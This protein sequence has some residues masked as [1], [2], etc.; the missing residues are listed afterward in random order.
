MQTHVRLVIVGA[1]IVGC[2]IAHHLT[3]LGWRDIV[4]VDKG[5]LYE[6]GGSSSHAPGLIF[7]TNYSKFMTQCAKYSVALYK[8]LVYNDTQ[9]AYQVGGIEVAYTDARLRE[10]HRKQSAALSYG[11]EGHVITPQEVADMVPVLDPRVIKGGYY[12]PT[13]TDVR[14][15]YCAAA[16]AEKAIAT[17]GATGTIVNDDSASLSIDDVTQ[18]EGLAS[19]GA[20]A[21]T[22]FVFT[23]SS[24]NPSA[25]AMT[26]NFQTADGTAT[27]PTDYV[28]SSGTVTIPPGATS[29]TL[30]ISVIPDTMVEPDETF[31][32]N[33]SAA[34]GASLADAQGLGTILGDDQPNPVPVNDPRALLL[35]IALMLSLAGLS[36]ARRR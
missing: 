10:L 7:Q 36:L 8:D 27:A 13:D 5:P 21:L 15:W 32:V 24:S 11:L 33:L 31:G 23:I 3:Q 14:G 29:A 35:L 12:V 26:V 18:F 2:S 1:G 9:C 19:R 30:V 22:P 17:G 6:T 20:G 4:V 34:V 28:A 16:L 25:T